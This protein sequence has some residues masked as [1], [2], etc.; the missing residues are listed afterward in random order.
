M[1]A[2]WR[3]SSA[4]RQWPSSARR[5]SAT[6]MPSVRYGRGWRSWPRDSASAPAWRAVGVHAERSREHAL[7]RLRAPTLGRE[8]ELRR[9]GALVG[10][11]ARVTIVAPPGVGKTRLLDELAAAADGAAV[12]RARLRPDV[13]SPFE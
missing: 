8:D 3:S 6:T 5:G 4:T 2:S 7:G 12:L 9:L 13:L 11:T 10:T 1:A